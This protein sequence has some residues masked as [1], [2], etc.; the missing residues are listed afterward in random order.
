MMAR[1]IFLQNGTSIAEFPIEIDGPGDLGDGAKKAFAEFRSQFPKL[2]LLDHGMV[3]RF[4]KM[5]EA[6]MGGA[7]PAR[8]R[9]RKK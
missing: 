4:A 2:S 9:K 7:R 1:A 8:T 3:V 5:E 6:S